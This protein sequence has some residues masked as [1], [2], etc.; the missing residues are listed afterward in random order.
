[1]LA[2]RRVN[3]SKSHLGAPNR[4][5][6]DG[7]SR[8]LAADGFHRRNVQFHDHMD[9][10]TYLIGLAES[11]Q[12]RFWRLDFQDLTPAEQVFRAIWE[13][14]GQVNNGGFEQY[15]TNCSGDL[16]WFAPTALE[17]I[18]ASKMAVIVQHACAVF[19]NGCPADSA[20]RHVQ[21][22]SVDEEKRN[23]LG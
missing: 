5:F 14:E 17:K 15:F 20:E 21:L 22:E 8:N 4:P 13:L 23:V 12:A 10:N 18:R 9:K 11:P 3:Y 16:A 2:R 6:V 7:L 19:P 1:M